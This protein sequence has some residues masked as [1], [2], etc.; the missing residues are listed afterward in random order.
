M[1]NYNSILQSH[2]AALQEILD[3][4]NALPEAGSSG[5]VTM[6]SFSIMDLGNTVQYQ[7]EG[8]MT[9]EQWCDSEYNINGYYVFYDEGIVTS[10][11][12]RCIINVSSKNDI[13]ISGQNYSTIGLD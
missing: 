8:G 7:A 3:T 2:N 4:I 6:I 13:I 5:G 9:W 11:G 1:P 12:L 10:D